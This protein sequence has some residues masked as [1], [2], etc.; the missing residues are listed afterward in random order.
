VQLVGENIFKSRGACYSVGS[1]NRKP[2]RNRGFEKTDN[3]TD[4][5][6]LK[7]EKN[8]KTDLKNRKTDK[9]VFSASMLAIGPICQYMHV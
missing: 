6:F 2:N 3:R 4:V 9:S 7:T 1:V 8:P 5:G